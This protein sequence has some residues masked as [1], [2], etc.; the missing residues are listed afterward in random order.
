MPSELLEKPAEVDIAPRKAAAARETRAQDE[1]LTPRPAKSDRPRLITRRQRFEQLVH[2][3][4]E[5]REEFLG[6]T[7]D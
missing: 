6:R 7:P 2:E 3:I 5:G 1:Q 4:F